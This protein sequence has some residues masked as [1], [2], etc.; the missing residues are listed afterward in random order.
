ML[1][2]QFFT[3]DKN[4]AKI[5]GEELF[6]ISELKPQAKPVAQDRTDR[7]CKATKRRDGRQS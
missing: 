5:I 7:F 6:K 2:L 1:I 4:Q 3:G